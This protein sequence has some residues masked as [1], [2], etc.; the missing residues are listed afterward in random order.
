MI[1]EANGAVEYKVKR[2]H[3]WILTIESVVEELSAEVYRE[4]E[5]V[6]EVIFKDD[7]EADT[8]DDVKR[9]GARQV[10]F[11][12]VICGS[13][14][15]FKLGEIICDGSSEADIHL[16]IVG[17]IV[18]SQGMPIDYIVHEKLSSIESVGVVAEHPG[19]DE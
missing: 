5:V 13:R 17:C 14:D 11:G 10:V 6:A 18:F 3:I 15:I 2:P 12:S 19:R 9:V 8:G 16:W 7:A 4:T 1:H